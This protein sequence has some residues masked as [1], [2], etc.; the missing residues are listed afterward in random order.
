MYF[1]AGLSVK[2]EII[3]EVFFDIDLTNTK[4][5]QKKSPPYLVEFM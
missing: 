5:T 2:K 1:C 3:K 4:E